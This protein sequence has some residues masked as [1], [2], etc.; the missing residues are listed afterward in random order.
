MGQLRGFVFWISSKIQAA[1]YFAVAFLVNG[2]G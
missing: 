1:V 2:F